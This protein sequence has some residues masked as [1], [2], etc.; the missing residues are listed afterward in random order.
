MPSEVQDALVTILSEKVLPVPELD[1]E[2]AAVQG[3]NLIATANDR[4]RGINELSSALRRRFNTVVLPLPATAEE[5]MAIVA[6]RVGELG[7][8]LAL[9]DV[10]AAADEIRRVVTIFRELREGVTDDGRTSLKQPTGTLSTAEAIS[11]VTNGLALAAHFGDGTL[12][13]DRRRRRHRRRRRPRPAARRRR[14]ARVP[15]GGGP[16]SRRLGRLLRRLPRPRADGHGRRRPGPCRGCTCSASATT[17]PARPARSCRAL[18]E[19]RPDVVLVEAPADA[20]AALRW[21]GDAGLVPPVA[22]L[23]YVVAEPERAVFA[24]ARRVQPGVAGRALGARATASAVEAIDLPLGVALR[25]AATTAPALPAR[26]GRPSIRSARSPRRPASPTPSGG[27]R[28]SSS[29]AATASR[30]STPSPR[31]WPPCAPAPSTDRRRRAA[32]GAHAP[33]HPRRRS[34]GEPRSVAVVCGAWH[35]PALD[36]S[37]DA[38]PRPTRP[39][40]RGRPKV[41]VAVTWVPWTHRRLRRATGYGAGVVSPGWY[42]HVFRHPGPRA[43]SRFFVDA[44][45][46]LRRRGMPASPDHLIA[47]LAARR[48]ARRAAPPAARRPR[49]GARRRRVGARRAAARRRRARRRRRH[50]RGARRTRPQVPLA[51]DLAASQRAARL[52]PDG[53]RRRSSSSTCARRTG[54]AARTCCTAS[55]RSASRGACSRRAAARAARSARRGG[56]RG[57]PSCRCASSSWPATARPSRRRRRP[58]SSS[59][60]TAADAARRRRGGR[61]PGAARRPARRAAAGRAR[62]SA[63]WPRATPTSAS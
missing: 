37:V 33:A 50:R 14:L 58:G 43:S 15:R 56:W 4:D 45:H 28:T 46:A 21:I 11:V 5:E 31:R 57:S 53:R 61:R 40:L 16:R 38:R 12:R 8:A 47:A 3:F 9:P 1:T 36:P 59:R 52:K 6:R 34:A 13:A 20:D 17:A 26:C 19:L 60:S 32:R 41:K 42:D 35:V 25:P 62:C 30:C 2:V 51:R 63:S 10:P 22:L 54:C 44:A 29:T 18:D 27:G 48:L 24:P 49:R 23:G 7:A 39:S 55:P